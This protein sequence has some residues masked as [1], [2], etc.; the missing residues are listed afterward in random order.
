MVHNG[1]EYGDMQ[2]LCEA[3]N[4]MKDVLKMTPDEMG[5]FIGEWNKG[6]LDSFLCEITRDI[7]KFKDE[8]GTPLVEKIRDT[9]GQVLFF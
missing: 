8:D 4:L 3:Y 7:L 6:E 2:I 1:I 5:D 9:A